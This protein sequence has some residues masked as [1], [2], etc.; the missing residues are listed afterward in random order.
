[1]PVL[2][3]VVIFIALPIAEIYVIIQV[4]EAIGPLATVLL[5]AADSVIGSLLL[6]SQGRRVWARFRDTL[7]RGD[8]P[9]REV[10]DGVLVIFGGAFLITPGFITDVIGA[11]LLMPPTRTL[12]RH[13]LVR[14]LGK[15]IDIRTSRAR[16]PSR[17]F[18]VEGTATEYE[19]PSPRLER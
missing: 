4:G 19:A 18:D 12:I 17:D 3:L 8:V 7:A 11:L 5:L 2:L 6:R 16:P 13:W 9:H 1:M 10:I 14:R 15:R